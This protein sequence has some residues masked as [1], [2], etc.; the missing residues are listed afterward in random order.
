MRRPFLRHVGRSLTFSAQGQADG[1]LQIGTSTNVACDGSW[2]AVYYDFGH[3]NN[4]P[5]TYFQYQIF[6]IIFIHNIIK[7]SCGT[8]CVKN[9]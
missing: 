9:K 3:E 7:M 1:L 6:S 2:L 4:V 8:P 5:K